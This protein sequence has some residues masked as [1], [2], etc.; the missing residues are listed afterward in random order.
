MKINRTAG[1]VAGVVMAGLTLFVSGCGDK[2]TEAGGASAPPAVK[3]SD[4]PAS[5]A[6][7]GQGTEQFGQQQGSQAAANAAAY[8]AAKAK[9]EGK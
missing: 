3:S 4:V 8:K 5:A 7:T 6:Q 9:A 1:L 2:T